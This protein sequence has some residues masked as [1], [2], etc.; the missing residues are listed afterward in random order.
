MKSEAQLDNDGKVVIKGGHFGID[1]S[2]RIAEY[3]GYLNDD[4]KITKVE[5][6]YATWG[7]LP[8]DFREDGHLHGWWIISE[9]EA[10]NKY[11]NVMKVTYLTI[12]PK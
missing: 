11:K 2:A 3:W 6:C 7:F 10:K 12:I 1:E 8:S 5:H 4:E 9:Y